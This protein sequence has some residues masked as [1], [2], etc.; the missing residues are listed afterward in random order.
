MLDEQLKCD[1]NSRDYLLKIGTDHPKIKKI[2][3]LQ[4]PSLSSIIASYQRINRA[5][6]GHKEA[7]DNRWLNGSIFYNNSILRR[8][9]PN[10]PKGKSGSSKEVLKQSQFGLK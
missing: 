3:D 2:I 5:F 10:L 6:H 7:G 8:T 4:L 9:R 1:I